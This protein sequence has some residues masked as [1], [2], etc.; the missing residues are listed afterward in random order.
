MKGKATSAPEE[1]STPCTYSAWKNRPSELTLA[2]LRTS[3]AWTRNQHKF[4]VSYS[5]PFCL[6]SNPCVLPLICIKTY[7]LKTV[8]LGRESAKETDFKAHHAQWF[9]TKGRKH[10]NLE[11][12]QMTPS[13]FISFFRTPYIYE[14][15]CSVFCQFDFHIFIIYFV[16]SE[17]SLFLQAGPPLRISSLKAWVLMRTSSYSSGL[18]RAFQTFPHS[19]SNTGLR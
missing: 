5:F 7:N 12:S 3:W 19:K 14:S 13:N 4:L 16:V 1:T 15:H 6:Y 9:V 11:E 18:Q 8:C 2:E 17:Y 10:L